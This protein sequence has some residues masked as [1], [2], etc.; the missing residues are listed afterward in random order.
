M[1]FL[2]KLFIASIRLWGWKNW[3]QIDVESNLFTSQQNFKRDLWSGEKCFSSTLP[4]PLSFWTL[5]SH[6]NQTSG[7]ILFTHFH[8]V[9][10]DH[11]RCR[12]W[13]SGGGEGERVRENYGVKVRKGEGSK[14]YPSRSDSSTHSHATVPL[15]AELLVCAEIR[16]SPLA[17]A[18]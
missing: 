18:V 10:T 5:V 13:M 8:A 4:L 16:P 12:L 14:S 2:K 1:S 15:P 7:N 6:L 3:F 9:V 17:L 11:V